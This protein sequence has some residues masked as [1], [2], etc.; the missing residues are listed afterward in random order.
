VDFEVAMAFDVLMG[1]TS[2]ASSSA[3][4]LISGRHSRSS[5]MLHVNWAVLWSCAYS[6]TLCR[7]G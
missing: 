3:D 4:S 1:F 2:R 6:Q 5:V 7:F